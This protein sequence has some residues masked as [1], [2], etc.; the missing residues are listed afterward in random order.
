VNTETAPG[1]RESSDVN[2]YEYS[3][4]QERH[5]FIP[6]WL[7]AVYGAMGLWMV[8]YLVVYWTDKG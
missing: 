4:I 8:Y 3:G 7:W 2:Q 6:K 1:E 5:G